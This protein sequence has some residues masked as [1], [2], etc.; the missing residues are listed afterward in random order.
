MH[1]RVV[2]DAADAPAAIGPYS[3]AVRQG[4][5]LYCSGMLPIDPGNG[6]LVCSSPGEE[7]RQC[8]RNLSRVCAAAG[9]TLDRALRM[10]VYTTE[11]SAFAEI[12][13][14]YAEFFTGGPPARDTVGVSALPKGARVEIDALVAL[15][16]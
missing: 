13:D 3:H 6:E 10:T 4:Q 2:I 7:A 12:N 8:L 16:D 9:A 15:R 1:D 14:A 11:L 5:T